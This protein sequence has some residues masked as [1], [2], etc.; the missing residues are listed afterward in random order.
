VRYFQ[1]F[2]QTLLGAAGYTSYEILP[3]TM[4]VRAPYISTYAPPSRM[5]WSQEES[6]ERRRR[7][8]WGRSDRESRVD[9]RD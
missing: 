9:E 2:G 3:R 5:Q 6:R 7:H 1:E 4:T 8:E